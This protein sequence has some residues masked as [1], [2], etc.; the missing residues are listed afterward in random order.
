MRLGRQLQD[1]QITVIDAAD[2]AP[3]TCP[4]CGGSSITD[5]PG[6]EANIRQIES[7]TAAPTA[8]SPPAQT[9]VCPKCGG[10]SI[11]IRADAYANYTLKGWDKDGEI[12]ANF[13][14]P[15]DVATFDDRAYVCDGCQHES[16]TSKT[17]A[18][19]E[20]QESD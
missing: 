4:Q 18:P 1:P 7:E 3:R 17:F 11:T 10:N 8:S 15:A 2:S 19:D 14:T 5:S 16:I 12:V 6:E 20:Y 9:P 13:A